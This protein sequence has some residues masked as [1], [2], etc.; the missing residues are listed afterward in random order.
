MN[1]PQVSAATAAEEL[2]R[3]HREIEDKLRSTVQDAIRAGE[4]LSKVKEQLRHGDILPWIKTNCNFSRQTADNYIRLFQ[5]QSKLPSVSNLQEAYKKV[6]TLEEQAKL[7]EEQRARQRVEEF[8]STGN[9]PEGWRRGT[10]DKLAEEEKKKKERLRQMQKEVEQEV[11]EEQ[12]RRKAAKP[13]P[14]DFAS[15]NILVEKVAAQAAKREA[16]KERIRISHEGKDDHFMDALMDYLD[17]LPDDSRR[18][19]ACIN[20]IKVAK[21]VA[22]QLQKVSA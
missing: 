5:Y 13:E 19:E 10:D 17:E 21:G 18:I 6:E 12:A 20:I 9:K 11:A 3:L 7:T 14:V 2:N 16:F 15:I 1:Y 22:N 8:T 4:I